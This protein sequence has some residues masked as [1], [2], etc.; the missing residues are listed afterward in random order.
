[1]YSHGMQFI[2]LVYV[3]YLVHITLLMFELVSHK[4]IP[5]SKNFRENPEDQLLLAKE[6]KKE[7]NCKY[8]L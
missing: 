5:D 8:V 6:E 4:T 2:C 7:K 3:Y 1:M